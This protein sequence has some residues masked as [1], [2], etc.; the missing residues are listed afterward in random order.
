[1]AVAKLFY[2][3]RAQIGEELPMLKFYAIMKREACGVNQADSG[4]IK[5]L[6]GVFYWKEAVVTE[7]FFRGTEHMIEIQHESDEKLNNLVSIL[8][9]EM[10]NIRRGE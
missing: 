1:M 3:I 2:D 6:A 4:K 10:K 8:K 7:G 9:R 5:P